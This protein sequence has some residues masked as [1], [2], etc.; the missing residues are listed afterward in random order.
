MWHRFTERARRAVFF[1]Q[2]EANRLGDDHVSTEHLLLGI[3]RQEDS[4]AVRALSHLAMPR[5]RVIRELK[6]S[7]YR[8]EGPRRYEMQLTPRAKRVIDLAYDEARLL[9]D[10]FIG[11]EHLLLALI[12][13]EGGLA[14]RVLHKLDV[15]LDATR[16]AL[17]V[18]RDR[19]EAVTQADDEPPVPIVAKIGHRGKM[20]AEGQ[21][22]PEWVRAF[23]PQ[24]YIAG[25]SA[26]GPASDTLMGDTL[27]EQFMHCVENV[28]RICEEAGWTLRHVVK[29]TVYLADLSQIDELD[30]AWNEAFPVMPP[31]RTVIG[32]SELPDGAL[33]MVEARA[34]L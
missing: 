34:A 30:K 27:A 6:R 8:S 13:E 28:Q 17:H 3:L 23:G 12:R 26:T 24:L 11:T 15:G 7:V 32:V 33:V 20:G 25:Q 29:A 9:N 10:N 4:N 2:E 22:S 5:S 31:V 19:P 14:G 1:A 18:I 21:I 16:K